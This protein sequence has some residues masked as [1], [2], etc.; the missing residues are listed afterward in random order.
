MTSTRAQYPK[1]FGSHIAGI[2]LMALGCAPAAL[3]PS[4]LPDGAVS[5]TAPAEYSATVQGARSWA[6]SRGCVVGVTCCQ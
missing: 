3:S 5:F 1:T 6:C 4:S 2:T